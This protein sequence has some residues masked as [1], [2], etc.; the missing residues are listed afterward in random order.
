MAAA[1]R[2]ACNAGGRNDAERDG[3]SEGMGGVVNIA[4][5]APGADPHSPVY[6]VDAYTLHH[7]QVDDET[8]IDAAE[9]GSVMATAA[10]GN[11][12]ATVAAEIDGRD[13]IGGV[14]ALGNQLRPLVDHAIIKR[15]RLVIVRIALGDQ[16][17][18]QALSKPIDVFVQHDRLPDLMHSQTLSRSAESSRETTRIECCRISKENLS[19]RTLSS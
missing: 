6:G 12:E 18:A 11:E 19:L 1:Q 10:Y 5:N 7:R 9:T 2:Q 4:R 16:P 3:K 8:V 13:D 17:A 15:A 14:C